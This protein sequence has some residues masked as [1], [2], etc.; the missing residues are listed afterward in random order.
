VLKTQICVTRPQC[1]KIEALNY[2]G[3]GL[4]WIDLAQDKDVW[5]AVV[6]TVM[7]PRVSKMLGIA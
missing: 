3:K 1:V 6:N 4:D 2:D 5:R 7:N